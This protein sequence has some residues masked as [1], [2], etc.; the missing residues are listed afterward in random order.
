MI[1]LGWLAGL[2][3]APSAFIISG[4]TWSSVISSVLFHAKKP[5][6]VDGFAGSVVPLLQSVAGLPLRPDARNGVFGIHSDL[7]EWVTFAISWIWVPFVITAGVLAIRALWRTGKLDPAY[8]FVILGLFVGL[9]KL[10]APQYYW[11]AV[12]ILPFCSPHI[13]PRTRTLWVLAAVFASL[14]LSQLIYPLHYTELLE[15]ISGSFHLNCKIFWVN[16]GKNVLWLT[17]VLL[18]WRAVMSLDSC[19]K[20]QSSA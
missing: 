20:L 14:Y 17:A 15:C 5:I 16:L 9:G 12:S 2:L 11:W 3:A 6:G 1:F 10:M 19:S 4:G 7:P 8:M 13:A 18:A